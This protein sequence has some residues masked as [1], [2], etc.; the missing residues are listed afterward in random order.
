MAKVIKYY[1][2]CSVWNFENDEH[3]FMSFANEPERS[4]IYR[5]I[6][7]RDIKFSIAGHLLA[8]LAIKELTGLEWSEI[9]FGRSK[10]G[11]PLLKSELNKSKIDFNISHSGD[12][13]IVAVIQYSPE[14]DIQIGCDVMHVQGVSRCN[15]IQFETLNKEF[16]KIQSIIYSQFGDNEKNWLMSQKDL[17]D[18]LLA[19]YRI[20]CLKESFIKAIGLGLYFDL[21]KI[22]FVI[23]TKLDTENLIQIINDSE[24]LIDSVKEN[25]F[26]FYE[27]GFQA[28]NSQFHIFTVCFK[29]KHET[30]EAGIIEQLNQ[31]FIEIKEGY[32]K[33]ALKDILKKQKN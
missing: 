21:K 14:F 33:T 22:D 2:N 16:M 11:K 5:F 25:S 1:F 18:K 19:F 9:N 4:R 8:K 12:F 7:K 6:H 32:L 31:S 27:Q 23:R 29:C 15:D 24:L 17:K 20:W 26:M 13:V 10:H 30:L 3:F 28:E